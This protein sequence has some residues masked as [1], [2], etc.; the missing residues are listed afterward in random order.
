VTQKAVDLSSSTKLVLEHKP[1]QSKMAPISAANLCFL[2]VL[3][4]LISNEVLLCFYIPSASNISP[5]LKATEGQQAFQAI[6]ERVRNAE[7]IDMNAWK[8]G[9][10]SCR[11]EICVELEGAVPLDLSGTYFRNGHGSFEIGKEKQPVL[12]PFDGDGMII[13]AQFENGKVL[14]RNRFVQTEG[15]TRE[16]NSNRALYR[17]TF[18][19]QRKGGFL[20]NMFDTNFKNVANTNVIYRAKRLFALWEG[21]LPH[22]LKPDSLETVGEESLGGLLEQNSQFSAHPRIDAKTGRLIISKTQR[23]LNKVTF[24][25]YE[26]DDE[27]KVV[28]ERSFDMPGFAFCHD[29]VVTDN[30]YIFNQAPTILDPLPFLLGFKGVGSCISFDADSPAKLFLVPRDADRDVEIVELDPHFNF[31]Y[32]NAFDEGLGKV[33]FDLVRSENVKL[34]DTSQN[35][36]VPLWE[37]LDIDNFPEMVPY[38]KLERY[39]LEKSSL[40]GGWEYSLESLSSRMIE[41]TS[42]APSVS[43]QKHRYV[44]GSCGSKVG[45]STPLQ[46]LIKVDVQDKSEE[47]WFGENYE[48]LGECIFTQSQ[49]P[50]SGDEDD[51]YV[52][53]VLW[54]GR[55]KISQLVVF[56]AKNIRQ[57]PI[58]RLDIPTNIPHG[59]HGFWAKDLLFNKDEVQRRFEQAMFEA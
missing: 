14:F 5:V 53:S 4:S 8:S 33:C 21:G 18:G 39:T 27:M 58:S 54:N 29:F 38:T 2:S 57:G 44:Y 56:D 17:N 9:F 48:F 3:V 46:G 28:K 13:A 19:T 35:P 23:G 24:T 37:L 43:C 32:A 25:V 47:T 1:T 52:L 16:K 22:Q 41:F 36:D 12:H 20:A 31:H 40:T 42:V 11:K 51:G 30:Y 49:Q 55:D 50:S 26:F 10:G 7:E 45:V 6:S 15:Y 59:L 34:G